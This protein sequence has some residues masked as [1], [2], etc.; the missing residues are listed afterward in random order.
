MSLEDRHITRKVVA[1]YLLLLVLAVCC[2]GYI[3]KVV[4]EVA[5]QEEN[6]PKAR[7]KTYLVTNTLSLLYESE[8][9]G[10]LLGMP[11]NEFR[12]FN[13]TLD[14]AHRNIDSLRLLV[15]DSVQRLKVDTIDA[16]L[17]RKRWNTR[18][19]LETWNE[20]N[21]ERLYAEN[22]E[23]VIA[24][25]DT[26]AEQ[27]EVQ[28]HLEIRQDTVVVP[29]PRRG[30]FR[31]LA[32]VF[33]PAREDTSIV[34]NSTRQVLTD[35]LV[36]VYNPSDTIV[37]VLKSIQDSVADRRNRLHDLLL[38]RAANLRYN[39][40]VITRRINQLLRDIEEEAMEAS[41]GRVEKKQAL[42][43]RTSYLIGGIGLVSVGIALVFM[44]LIGRDV[45]RSQYY[46]MQLEKAK[47]YAEDLLRS[48]EKLIL[49]ISHDIRAPLSSIIGY[50]EL[51]LRRRPDE[52][53]RYFLENMRGSSD[54]ILSLVND[55]LDY[56]RLE[57]GE[58]E[59]HRVPF[60]LADL[61]DEIYT[62]FKPLAEAKGLE[63]VSERLEDSESEW[64]SGDPMRLRQ[65]IG[66]LLSN[67]IKFTFEGRVA[68]AVRIDPAGV[69]ANAV[70]LTVTVSDSGPGIR[71]E[72][73]EKIF[74]EFTRLPG[75]EEVEGFGLGLSITRKLIWLMGGKLSLESMPGKGS[76]FRFSL[77]LVRA[78]RV[79][80]PAPGPEEVREA[81][82]GG[83][84]GQ[85]EQRKVYCLLVDDDPLQLA[86]TEEVLK[87]SHIE[88][89]GCTNPYKVAECLESRKF[90]AVITDIQMPGLDGYRLLDQ[91]RRS[92]A[93]DAAQV[94][95]I[96]LSASVAKEPDH[97]LSAGFAGFLNKPFTAAQLISLLNRLL[98][99]HLAMPSQAHRDL[100]FA[101]LTAFAGEDKAASDSILHT[102]AQETGKSIAR[103]Q[104]A[105]SD[106]DRSEA[107][108]VS[109]KLIP[110]FTM[111]GANALVQHLRILEKNDDELTDSGW[112]YLLGQVIARAS[113]VVDEALRS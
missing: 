38:E 35:T 100:N 80:A 20:S 55:L 9:L 61:V 15:R 31:R 66:N 24:V 18:K 60:C 113:A 99:L 23:K 92:G 83:D 56:Q 68:L 48:R 97:Y 102:F 82:K 53:Q 45:S 57:A 4:E 107:A 5:G 78:D 105:L 108:R 96:A 30:F 70:C 106:S 95:V 71:P 65:V 6:D 27:V 76:D 86:L 110:L 21:A 54:H 1:G 73:Q 69:P 36:N 81:G 43:R 59:I 85:A 58:M 16:L 79:E 67:A 44:L 51:L 91:I 3:Y 41:M 39:N 49:T 63:F 11:Q 112:Q 2:V 109:H 62:S 64:V 42:L 88:V 111:L 13:R 14:K 26:T 47:K 22:I 10:Q 74:G 46:R 101:S 29:R 32:E 34:V 93:P 87:Q 37:S 77:P 75:A 12:H 25:Q 19:L 103:L 90:D 7:Q 84:T 104:Q 52:R 40:T 33:A 28:E 8:A 89:M 17:E 94:P 50:I 98:A 72:E